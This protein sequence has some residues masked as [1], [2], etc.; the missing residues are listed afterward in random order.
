MLCKLQE[1]NL[2][3]GFKENFPKCRPIGY[4]GSKTRPCEDNTG[5][6]AWGTETGTCEKT[7]TDLTGDIVQVGTEYYAPEI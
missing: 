6:P 7:C 1:F 3:T 2:T 4:E 5:S